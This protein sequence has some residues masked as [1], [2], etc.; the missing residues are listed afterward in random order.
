MGHR[1]RQA[2]RAVIEYAHDQLAMYRR[3]G[4]SALSFELSEI[5][6]WFIENFEEDE[7]YG[8]LLELRISSTSAAVEWADNFVFFQL[9]EE[10]ALEYLAN[11]D[12]PDE[13]PPGDDDDDDDDQP[14]GNAELL[15]CQCH[16]PEHQEHGRCSFCSTTQQPPE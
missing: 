2:A 12:C 4:Q 7:V 6:E 8:A 15:C 11:E 5:W 13:D 16:R 3:E 1:R 9:D 14:D 10:L